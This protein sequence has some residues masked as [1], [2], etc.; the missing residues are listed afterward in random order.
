[1]PPK[2]AI[3]RDKRI[4]KRRGE[5]SKAFRGSRCAISGLLATQKGC[6]RAWSAAFDEQKESPFA[7]ARHIG[8]RECRI[9]TR[10][11]RRSASARKVSGLLIRG[12]GG[13]FLGQMRLP[14]A[15][16]LRKARGGREKLGIFWQIVQP[17]LESRPQSGGAERH[18]VG[19]C[20][21]HVRKIR[22]LSR[23]EFHA[24]Q[25]K[26]FDSRFR[27]QQGAHGERQRQ[28]AR[29]RRVE[30]DTGDHGVRGGGGR[31]R[32]RAFRTRKQRGKR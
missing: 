7:L 27:E 21:K 15:H 20:Q 16:V 11:I 13:A 6:P 8:S 4:L 14:I 23:A 17:G 22:G 18:R 1:M 3:R 32:F 19:A 29:L 5:K 2:V 26:A 25:T 30:N 31:S 24:P 12:R 28:I 9:R 10:K